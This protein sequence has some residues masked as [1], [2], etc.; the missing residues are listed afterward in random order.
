[1]LWGCVSF[2][3]MGIGG[4]TQWKIC[5]LNPSSTLAMFFEVVNQVIDGCY[6]KRK[7]EKKVSLCS[8]PLILHLLDLA[9]E[10]KTPKS[11]RSAMKSQKKS[12]PISESTGN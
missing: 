4:T 9:H 7:R 12:L 10:G 3:E 11:V 6:S 2:Q 5:G 1:M 8:P